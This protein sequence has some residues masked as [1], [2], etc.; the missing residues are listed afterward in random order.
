LKELNYLLENIAIFANQLSR[1]SIAKK[2]CNII[3]H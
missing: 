3:R 2:W 1:Y